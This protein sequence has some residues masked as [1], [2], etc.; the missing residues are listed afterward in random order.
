MRSAARSDRVLLETRPSAGVL[1]CRSDGDVKPADPLGALEVGEHQD[2]E[3]LGAGSRT[4]HIEA[5]PEA[6]LELV[7]VHGW[8]IYAGLTWKIT[9]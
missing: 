1:V 3:Q 7:G 5:L 9:R 4:E 2:V 8:G 6:A